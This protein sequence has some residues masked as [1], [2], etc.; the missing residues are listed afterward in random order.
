MKTARRDPRAPRSPCLLALL[1]VLSLSI[2]R[3][4]A[5]VEAPAIDLRGLE[6]ALLEAAPTVRPDALRGA[7]ASF[8]RLASRGEA[9]RGLLTVID[10]SL[11]ST[12]PRLWVFDLA[13]KQLRFHELVAHG[14]NSGANLARAFS[15]VDGSFMTSLGSFVTGTT[16][17]GRNGYSLRL[18]G[19]DPSVNDR[20]EARAIVM[21]G[22]PYVSEELARR[23]G[24]IGRSHGCP[25]LRPAI[26]REVIDA[27]QGGSVVYAWHPTVRG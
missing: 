5:G 13:A 7:L 6:A 12:V 3:T 1:A 23:Q 22:A 20:A 17:V 14:R 24:R 9:R 21:H 26:A 2:G 4:E 11:P 25:A 19:M 15:N 8:E 10:Y 16:Y 18:R 27:I